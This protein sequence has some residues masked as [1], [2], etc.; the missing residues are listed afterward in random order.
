MLPHS[1]AHFAGSLMEN[2]ELNCEFCM[3]SQPHCKVVAATGTYDMCHA[4]VT[5]AT[6]ISTNGQLDR[7]LF[8][9]NDTR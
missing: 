4:H 8:S 5:C 2:M 9:I 7:L 1:S 6:H 3:Q